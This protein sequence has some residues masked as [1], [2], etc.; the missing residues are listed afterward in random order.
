[1]FT[2]LS[3]G[4]VILASW[5]AYALIK[6]GEKKGEITDQLKTLFSNI[7][8]MTTNV[9]KLILLLFQDTV[10]KDPGEFFNFKKMTVAPSKATMPPI[11][12]IKS[13][14]I[15]S[16]QPNN[17]KEDSNENFGTDVIDLTNNNE[18]KAA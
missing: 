11:E 17:T 4:F 13:D 15:K 2:L 1:M 3:I 6:Q 9:G 18:E 8:D 5:T 7:K 14:D 12:T 10:K 16:S